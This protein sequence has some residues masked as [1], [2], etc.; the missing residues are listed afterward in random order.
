M[1]FFAK[2]FGNFIKKKRESLKLSQFDLA[3]KIGVESQTVSRWEVGSFLP[4]EKTMVKLEEVFKVSKVELIQSNEHLSFSLAVSILQSL[5]KMPPGYR[6][7]CLALI[8]DD[9]SY[10]ENLPDSSRYLSVFEELHTT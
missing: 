9:R 2:A 8:L 10:I 5:S 1:G 6:A 7:F 3:E 4:T